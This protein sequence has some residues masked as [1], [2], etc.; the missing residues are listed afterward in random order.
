MSKK[1][2]WTIII[3]FLVLIFG[4]TAAGLLKPDTERSEKENRDLAQ[5][6]EVTLED[7]LDGSF[8][9][10]Y[11]T[12][13]TDQ[14]ILRD[15]W[16]GIKT[17]AERAVGKQEVND[18][19]FAADDYL[20][21]K[22]SG[23]FDTENVR[24]NISYLAEFLKTWQ[25]RLGA[26]HVK[27]VIA[28]NALEILEEKLPPFASGQEEQDFFEI[29]KEALPAESFVDVQPALKEHSGEY[30][31]YRTDHHWTTLGAWYAYETW[32][33]AAG[34][35]YTP[36]EAYHQEILT[37]EFFGTIE[38]KV[39]VKVSADTI[40]AWLP[41]QEVFYRL[42]FNHDGEKVR[43]SLY[44]ESYLEV[45]DKYAVFFG[46]NQPLTEIET[47]AKNGRRL[48]IIKDS[49]ANC[50]APFAVQDFERISMVDMRYFNERLSEYIADNDFTDILFL[51]NA[52][53][54][55]EDVS[56]AKLSL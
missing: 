34:V 52:S 45:R 2:N 20:I 18:I 47:E 12:Y 30:I 27:A 17:M 43:D 53:G 40:E 10:A 23:V 24:K 21:E 48:L 31:Y 42:T 14:F 28:P 6:P 33:K 41:D 19:Y 11:E 37:E 16:I 51:Y 54:F 8:S 29:V 13:L 55:A 3:F 36:R 56:L 7:V 26:E 49:Y 32:A 38:A 9:S 39:N 46:G 4:F 22:H 35:S 50:F 15:K 1:Q 5:M 25:E 44:D